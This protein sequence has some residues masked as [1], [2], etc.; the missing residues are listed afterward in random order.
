MNFIPYNWFTMK[1]PITPPS[2]ISSPAV[3]LSFVGNRFLL[4]ACPLQ[5]RGFY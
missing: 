4:W 1:L 3:F 5:I 2:D